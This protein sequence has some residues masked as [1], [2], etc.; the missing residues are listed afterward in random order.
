MR[1]PRDRA[2]LAEL[3]CEMIGPGVV[4]MVDP[5]QGWPAV[6]RVV[7]STGPA[8]VALH[9]GPVG[10][11]SRKTHEFRFQNLDDPSLPVAA[12]GGS[13]PVLVGVSADPV[14]V[15]VVVD[16]RSR[17]GNAKRFSLLF[18]GRV[19]ADAAATGW[20]EYVS[21]RGEQ[22]AGIRPALFP[23]A[24]DLLMAGLP[25]SSSAFSSAAST[26]GLLAEEASSAERARRAASALV[27]DAKFSLLVRAA[28]EDRCAL[29]G[30]GIGLV[31]GAHILPVGAQGSPDAVWNGVA[32]C[33]NHH[34]AFDTHRIYVDP[35]T[36]AVKQHR[37]ILK[38]AQTDPAVRLFS[39]GTAA[40]L[41][42]PKAHADRPRPSMFRARSTYFS[43]QYKWA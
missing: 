38:I 11:F 36:L 41:R 35:D 6:V 27:R 5:K 42:L 33:R 37:S 4:A 30:L 39:E 29:C 14:P 1:L 22:F 7:T 31:E 28:Y 32:L 17:R 3:A 23:L 21:K 2:K 16:G 19:L 12:P 24:V 18:H 34:R 8:T 40:S 9:V 25:L 20:G 26:L 43:D 10:T 13:L 15:L